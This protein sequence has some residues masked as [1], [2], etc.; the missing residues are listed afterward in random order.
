MKKR[1]AFR[2]GTMFVLCAVF[3]VLFLL[4]MAL[5]VTNSF[6][7]EAEIDENYGMIFQNGAGGYL[8]DTAHLKLIPDRATLSQYRTVFGAS[9]EYLFKFRNSLLLVVPIVLGQLA[10][11]SAA[12]YSF[13]CR[14]SRGRRALFFLYI[15]LMLMPYQVTLVPN[16]LVS[17]WLGILNT[18]A[19]IILPG[20]FAP[21]SVFLLTKFM[22]R[23]PRQLLEAARLDGAGAW[24]IFTRICLPQCKG[25]LASVAILSFI[26]YWNMVEQPL[27]LL[28]D[29]D[30]YP[31]SVFL[32]SLNAQELG[33]AFAMAAV[34]M[35]PPLLLFLWGEKYLVE[36][37]VSSGSV[38]G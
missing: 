20:V 7:S 4:P 23:I 36:G 10:V 5:T 1:R 31:L 6:M 17:R 37:I 32:S 38:R 27:V 2:R 21:L 18:R 29:T 3:A 13:T 16:Y 30:K 26:D 24:Q 33:S 8:S 28:S 34:Y 25:A 19:A 12:A 14:R 11:A 15:V 9:P 22:R 35:L